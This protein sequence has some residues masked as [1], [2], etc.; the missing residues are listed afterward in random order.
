MT[1][2][3]G[4][5]FRD[6]IVKRLCFLCWVLAPSF[7]LLDHNLGESCCHALGSPVE[8]PSVV[9]DPTCQQPVSELESRPSLSGWS[10]QMSLQPSQEPDNIAETP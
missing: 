10:L 6:W 2:I 8:R 7:S 4:R 9:R 3:M 1:E 5:R